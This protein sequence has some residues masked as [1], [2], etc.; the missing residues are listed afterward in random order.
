MKILVGNLFKKEF[1]KCSKSILTLKLTL[2]I[3]KIIIKSYKTF[4]NKQNPYLIQ[5]LQTTEKESSPKAHV[6]DIHFCLTNIT[7]SQFLIPQHSVRWLGSASFLLH[8][9]FV[10]WSCSH[11]EAPITW[12][13]QSL[14][15]VV[16]VHCYWGLSCSCSPMHLGSPPQSLTC[17][18]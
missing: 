9:I 1:K 14:T 13:I 11:L 7:N 8:V 6:L 2:T 4:K 16:V 18:G 5:W 15:W 17:V 3:A 12:N 10:T